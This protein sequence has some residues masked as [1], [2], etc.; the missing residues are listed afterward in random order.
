MRQPEYKATSNLSF[1]DSST[2]TIEEL[3]VQQGAG[4]ALEFS[5]KLGGSNTNASTTAVGFSDEHTEQPSLKLSENWQAT[6]K[7]IDN[8]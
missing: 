4:L 1:T 6:T 2:W 7:Y 3:P 8:T 5:R